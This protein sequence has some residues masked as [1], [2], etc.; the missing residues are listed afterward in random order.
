MAHRLGPGPRV[1]LGEAVDG[2]V[3][4][5]DAPS[6][7]ESGGVGGRSPW[8]CEPG[9]RGRR[10][11][12]EKQLPQESASKNLSQGVIPA[13]QSCNMFTALNSR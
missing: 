11:E 8:S 3:T 9:Q 12:A 13:H 2:P 1:F 5:R 7:S 6:D 4:G 10:P